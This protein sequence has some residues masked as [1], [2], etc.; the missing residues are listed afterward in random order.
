M[1]IYS[2]VHASRH[3]VCNEK[4]QLL[5]KFFLEGGLHKADLEDWLD[6]F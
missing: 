2:R 1:K 5:C 6:R 4:K 3:E